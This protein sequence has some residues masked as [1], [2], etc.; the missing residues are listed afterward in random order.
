[1]SVLKKLR[2]TTTSEPKKYQVRDP[3]FDRESGTLNEGMM[4][5]SYAFIEDIQRERFGELKRTL[6]QARKEKDPEA[7]TK[8]KEMIGQ[9][10][11]FN[12]KK[13]SMQKERALLKEAKTENEQ[14]VEQGLQ[15]TYLKKRDFKEL[16]LKD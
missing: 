9:E 12:R 8:L 16:R 13:L 5:K 6:K 14:R 10:K 2:H 1:M 7:T 15:P 3:R 4:H 11:I